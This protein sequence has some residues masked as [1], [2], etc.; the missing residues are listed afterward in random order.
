[1]ADTLSATPEEMRKARHWIAD[2]IDGLVPK[3]P[4]SFTYNGESSRDFLSSADQSRWTW[5]LKREEIELDEERTGH[6]LT[7]DDPHTGL[8]VRL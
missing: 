2:A 6:S 8:Q 3:L 7:Y 1:M 5:D 4:F